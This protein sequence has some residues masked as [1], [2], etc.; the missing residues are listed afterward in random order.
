[1][2][3]PAFVMGPG[4]PSHRLFH[5]Y[6]HLSDWLPTL[7]AAAGGDV[8]QLGPLDGINQWHALVNDDS[9]TGPRSEMLLNILPVE[10]ALIDGDF[11]LYAIWGPDG[12]GHS[13][14]DGWSFYQVFLGVGK[15]F[16]LLM[17]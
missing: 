5:S 16:E 9:E 7:Y 1:M 12:Q 6:F 8:T 3:V 10:K 15:N 4:I 17:H 11:K 2:R 13:Y 14:G